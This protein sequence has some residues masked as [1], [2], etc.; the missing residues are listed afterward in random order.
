M[1]DAR[2]ADG[3]WAK[4]AEVHVSGDHN[5]QADRST[6][7]TRAVLEIEPRNVP[8]FIGWKTE[9][10]TA[11]EFYSQPAVTLYGGKLSMGVGDQDVWFVA[12]PVDG[13]TQLQL[14]V[15]ELTTEDDP[16]YAD[17]PSY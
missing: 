3:V 1:R 10:Y 13:R 12:R 9:R 17:L 16:K 4:D 2:T 11:A 14:Y 5:V 8:F 15:V 6:W 7:K